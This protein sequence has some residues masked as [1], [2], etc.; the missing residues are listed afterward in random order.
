M[1]TILKNATIVTIDPHRRVLSDAA[2]VLRDDRIEAIE[3]TTEVERLYAGQAA[4]VI[5]CRDRMILPGI[6][7]AHSHAGHCMFT[8]LGYSTPSRWMPIMTKLYHH[9]TTDRFWYREARLAALTRLSAGITTGVSMVTNCG[10]ADDVSIFER[11]AAGY[12]NVGLRGIVAVGPNNPPFPRTMTRVDEDGRKYT[13]EISFE[14]MLEV[15]DE[16]VA[17]LHHSYNDTIRAFTA[18]FVLVTS[19]EGSEPTPPELAA[20]L[21]DHDRVMMTAIREI[22]RD[23]KTRIHTEAFGGMVRLAA[24]HKDALL[25]PDV[26][27]QHCMGISLEEAKILADTGTHVTT[28]PHEQQFIYA[29]PVPELM[30]MGANVA[31]SSDGTGPASPFDLFRGARNLQLVHRG[32][33]RDKYLFPIGT[34]LEMITINAAKAIGWD[35]EIGSLEV[36]KKADLI[37]IDLTRP[38]LNP[39]IQLLHKL[40]IFGNGGDVNDVMVNGTWVIRDRVAQL[41]DGREIMAEADQEARETIARAGAERHI[42]PES[43]FWGGVRRE[44]DEPVVV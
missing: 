34:L 4:E 22:A 21:T 5:D 26:H 41:A 19:V 15:T 9:N 14:R 2:I 31:V 39:R 18:P 11:I 36:G 16:T 10:R 28:T 3:A 8:A 38:Y 7:D 40:F 23:R 35:D 30:T 12:H 13:T 27:L 6:V 25:G 24:Q 43:T 1:L 44:F 33:L 20:Q 32:R 37:T 17:K 42:A 29:C